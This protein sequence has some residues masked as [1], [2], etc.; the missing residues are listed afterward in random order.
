MAGSRIEESLLSFAIDLHKK[1]L[2]SE[3]KHENVFYSPFS[4][5]VA[6]SM[7]FAGAR[8]DTAKQISDV[9]HIKG[10]ESLHKQFSDTLS[11]VLRYGPDVELR[12]A[13]R[14]VLDASFPIL[15]TYVDLLKHAYSSSVSVVDFENDFEKARIEVNNW[16]EQATASKIKNLL[17]SGSLDA[18]TVLVLV[19]AV[20]FKGEWK[21]PFL[22]QVTEPWDFRVDSSRTTR[23]E[24]MYQEDDFRMSRCD[25]LN[26][27]ALEIP[28]RGGKVSMVVLLPDDLGGLCHLEENLSAIKL[29][30]LLNNLSMKNDVR[31]RLPK[32]KLEHS[33]DLEVALKALGINTVFTPDADLAG[34]SIAKKLRVSK[35]VHKAFVEIDEVGTEASAATAV[36]FCY[37]CLAEEIVEFIVDR[38]FM[39]LIRCHDPDVVLFVGS[40]RNP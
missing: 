14:V 26:V 10:N 31:L 12:V 16:V 21:T 24:M 30:E 9:L 11:K 13:N 22:H 1:L 19:N 33:I 7:V 27:T 2:P 40:V 15:D 35:I 28:Y 18:L 29:R 39:L 3:D 32:F 34:I 5:S 8:S 37:E 20:Y 25:D 23:V 6:L 4:I 17:V 38:P 36:D